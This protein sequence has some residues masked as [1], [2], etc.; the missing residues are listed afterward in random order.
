[1]AGT[2]EKAPPLEGFRDLV[3]HFEKG[4]K[5]DRA[6]WRI[7]TEH[8]KFAFYHD[9]LEPVPYEGER[10]I[11][12]LLNTLADKYGWERIYEG[13]NVIALKQGLASITL[14]PGGQ[15][16]LSGAPLEHL[17]Q[18]CA[19]TGSHLSQLRDVCGPMGIAFLGVGFSPLWSLEETPIMPKGRY[20]IMRA[21]MR[22]VGRLGRQMMF[23]SCTVQTNLDFASES[24]MVKKFRVGLA[25]AADR[26]GAVCGVARSPK[27]APTASS[28]IA[29]ISGPTPIP[30][31]PACCRSCSKTAWALNATPN[32]RS[33]C[34]CTSSIA[35]ANISTPPAKASAPSWTPN[36]RRC[37][38][39]AP[40][41]KTGKIT[42][43]R[44]FRKC[45]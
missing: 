30:T 14:E 10:G 28:P 36:C 34:R 37:Q 27:A 22:K 23:R 42:S 19:E 15:F 1:M 7:G 17:H 5:P 41:K 45:A 16:E 12:A 43:P 20:Q 33:M 26:D 44:F 4:P 6:S 9:T 40:P 31:A 35:T 13:D 21:Y 8:E 11:G 38:A 18:T 29:A 3:A 24:D 25:L 32:T 2:K 39:S